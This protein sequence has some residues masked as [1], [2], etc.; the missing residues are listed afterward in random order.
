M[1]KCGASL[2]LIDGFITNEN[3]QTS[4]THNDGY[5]LQMP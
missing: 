4:Y 3:E 2:Q 1:I 5:E